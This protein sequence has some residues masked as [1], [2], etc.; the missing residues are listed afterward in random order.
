MRSV[1]SSSLTLLNVYISK[2]SFRLSASLRSTIS[3]LKAAYEALVGTSSI[4]CSAVFSKVTTRS[5]SRC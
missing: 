4:K 1:F 5:S 2:S 3:C